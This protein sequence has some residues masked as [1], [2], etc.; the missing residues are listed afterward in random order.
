MTKMSKADKIYA[1]IILAALALFIGQ[2]LWEMHPRVRLSPLDG[3]TCMKM[4]LHGPDGEALPGFFCVTPSYEPSTQ[5]RDS[6]E[7]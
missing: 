2:N 7:A 3:M 6:V 5:G 4:E 1:W